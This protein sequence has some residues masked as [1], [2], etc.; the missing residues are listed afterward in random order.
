[1]PVC[2]SE[3]DLDYNRQGIYM[4]A[5]IYE[6][7]MTPDNFF[8]ALSDA[9]RLRTLMLMQRRGELCVCELAHALKLSQP[10]ISRHLAVLRETQMVSDRRDGLWVFY[11]VHPNLPRWTQRVLAEALAGVDGKR[12]YA[13][14]AQRFTEMSDRPRA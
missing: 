10:K 5:A 4:Q 14:D 12:P 9:T 6:S 7:R 13:Q 1:M 8:R 3:A 2:V 11:R